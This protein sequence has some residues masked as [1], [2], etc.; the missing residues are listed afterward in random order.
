MPHRGRKNADDVLVVALACGATIDT[1]AQRAGVA[2]R[3]VNRRLKDPDFQ[4]RLAEV[5]TD[6]VKRAT[7]VLTA[8]ALEAVKTLMDLQKAATPAA[9]RLGA[10]RTILEFGIKLR[11]ATEM[12]ERIAALEAQLAAQPPA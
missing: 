12:E 11:E 6:M 3:T 2:V 10:A 9:V 7:G 1:A 5:R 8:A 4:K